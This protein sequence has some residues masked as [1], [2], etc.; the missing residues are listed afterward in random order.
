MT[1]NVIQALLIAFLLFIIPAIY[2]LVTHG[3]LIRLLGGV[4]REEMVLKSDFEQLQQRVT[5]LSSAAVRYD[6]NVAIHSL[7]SDIRVITSKAAPQF[8]LEANDDHQ[9]A[10]QQWKL[11]KTK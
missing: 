9:L 10:A 4:N 2:N 7:E 3:G 11:R 8:P 5:E 6:E 1:K